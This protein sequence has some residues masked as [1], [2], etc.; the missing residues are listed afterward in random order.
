MKFQ[1]RLKR[2]R[3]LK[4]TKNN[5]RKQ[6]TK[7]NR[8]KRNKPKDQNMKLVLLDIQNKM[9]GLIQ[10]VLRKVQRKIEMSMNWLLAISN[11]N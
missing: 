11:K 8:S 1:K 10:L 9:F 5:K 4:Q 6:L 3:N 7:S 2:P